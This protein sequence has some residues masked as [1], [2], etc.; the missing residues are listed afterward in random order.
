MRLPR[1]LRYPSPVPPIVAGVWFLLVL[2]G[3]ALGGVFSWG[4]V[5]GQYALFAVT[6]V[7]G[8]FLF[9]R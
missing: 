7:V 3:L 1:F 6:F 4:F 8:Y 2:P 9:R 5:F